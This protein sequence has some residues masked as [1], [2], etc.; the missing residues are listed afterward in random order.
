VSKDTPAFPQ[1]I[2]DT[3]RLDWLISTGNYGL[4]DKDAQAI[5][6]TTQD[7]RNAIDDAMLQEEARRQ[8]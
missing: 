6:A 7:V 2:T 4:L 1:P 3:Q 5:D 8:K